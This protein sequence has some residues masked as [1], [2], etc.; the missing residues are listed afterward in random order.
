MALSVL[1]AK[2]G[3]IKSKGLFLKKYVW[4]F[5]LV[6]ILS[7]IPAYLSHGQ[8]PLQTAMVT[9][10]MTSLFF[11]YLFFVKLKVTERELIKALTIFAFVYTFFEYFQQFTYPGSYWFGGRDESEYWGTLEKRQG[12]WKFYMYG[13][14]YLVIPLFFY[15][16]KLLKKATYANFLSF[17]YLVA[18]LYGFLARKFIFALFGCIVFSLLTDKKV[19]WTHWVVITLFCAVVYLNVDSLFAEYI[20]KTKTDLDAGDD[21]VRARSTAFFLSYFDDPLCLLFGNGREAGE[22]EYGK[23]IRSLSEYPLFTRRGD[24]G[25]YAHFSF[26]GIVGMV[27]VVLFIILLFRRWRSMP[28]YIKMYFIYT[29]IQLTV[30]FPL[31]SVIGSSTLV[32]I[33][34]LMELTMKNKKRLDGE[35]LQLSDHTA[36]S[37]DEPQT[38][39]MMMPKMVGGA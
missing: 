15:W 6:P 39:M 14:H 27:P 38:K 7:I 1:P 30:A 9:T 22:S 3:S 2:L 35:S 32:I 20:E 18:G 11:M 25:I 24:I 37:L 13:I 34:Y 31:N 26:Y 28:L 36:H 4:L 5:M 29:L 10:V 21:W 16:E 19:K 17:L 8:T 23:Y 33:M 12:L